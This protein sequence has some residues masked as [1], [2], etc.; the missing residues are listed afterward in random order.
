MKED[1]LM[2]SNLWV[3]IRWT[4]WYFDWQIHGEAMFVDR[5][6]RLEIQIGVIYFRS[7]NMTSRGV[8]LYLLSVVGV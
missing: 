4:E 8:G 2:K 6:V 5:R 7:Q 3:E 1:S